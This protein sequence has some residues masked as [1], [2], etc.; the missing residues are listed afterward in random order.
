M[1]ATSGTGVR[2][3]AL[4][5]EIGHTGAVVAPVAV[6]VE[7]DLVEEED[8]GASGE[9]AEDEEEGDPGDDPVGDF[10]H[11]ERGQI[12]VLAVDDE[13]FE[14]REMAH[15]LESLLRAL[16]QDQAKQEA[17]NKSSHV[18]EVANLRHETKP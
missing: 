16:Q 2:A 8:D 10:V 3:R 7:I 18:G 14:L 6:F 17:G 5:F 1:D 11:R 13:S 9:E 4:P 12:R 15:V